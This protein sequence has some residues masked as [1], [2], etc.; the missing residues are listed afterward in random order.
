MTE[1]TLRIENMHCGS[2]IRR[3][4][5]ALASTQGL[6]VKEVRVGAARVSSTENPAPVEL[7][8]A[9]LAKAGYAA[10]LEN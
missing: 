2:C 7:A 4:S 5:Q 3:V 9:A 1:F 6:Q 8:V 10:R